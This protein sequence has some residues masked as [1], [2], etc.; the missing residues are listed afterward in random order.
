[1]I[2]QI[3]FQILFLILEVITY[4]VIIALRA[5]V[6]VLKC[7]RMGL[8]FILPSSFDKIICN[9]EYDIQYDVIMSCKR[10]IW[11]YK[12]HC[13]SYLYRMFKF[14]FIRL[15]RIDRLLSIK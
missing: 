7:F 11:Y 13:N 2:Q 8:K 12:V 1:M 10:F 15:E 3:L 14:F 4:Y 9:F 6:L 5:F